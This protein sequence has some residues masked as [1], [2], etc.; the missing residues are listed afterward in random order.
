[1]RSILMVIATFALCANAAFGQSASEIES[2]Y[3]K[4][5]NVYSVSERVWMTPAY[6]A[7][8]QVCFMRLYPKRISTNTNY[9]DDTLAMGE[10]LK[11]IDELIPVGSRG[12]RKDAFGMTNTGGGVA[13]THFDYDHVTFTF[14]SSFRLDKI[15]ESGFGDSFDF[16]FDAIDEQALTEA[17]RRE[18]MRPDSELM[19]ERAA[20]PKVLEIRWA[21]RK[22]AAP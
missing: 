6:D 17:L 12:A 13:W 20:K 1:M 4:P 14:V 15:P 9:L 11:V 18:A 7:E 22:C 19:R 21:G 10:V 2:K 8:G 3:G 5:A 16:K